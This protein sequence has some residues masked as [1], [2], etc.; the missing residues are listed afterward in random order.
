[1]MA[2]RTPIAIPCAENDAPTY[3]FWGTNKPPK[4]AA[5]LCAVNPRV[6]TDD[7]TKATLR[8]YGPI[9]SWGG[10]WGT[11]AKEVAQ[12]LDAL[13]DDVTEIQLRVN[14]PGGSVFEGLAILNL[15]RAHPAT[16]TAV[17][18]G[19]AASAA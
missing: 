17:V 13:G 3:R 4:N 7:P 19:L 16:V 18:D 11:S 6:A 12:A 1:L 2:R 10:Y 8:L 9:D 5:V 14:S 15:L